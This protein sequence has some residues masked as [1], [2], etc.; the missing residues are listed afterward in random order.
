MSPRFVFV[1][2]GVLSS[3]GKGIASS[4]LGALL[5]ARGFRVRLRKLDP[6]LNV[7]S[8]TMS[9]LQHGEVFVTDDGTET[10]LDLGHYERF[11]G[12][13]ASRKDCLTTGRIYLEVFRKERNGD[14]LGQTIQVIPHIVDEIKNTLIQ[15]AEEN[16]FMIFEIGG[17]VGDIE[18]LPFLE[19]I[20]QL[21]NELGKERTL[22][23]HTAW[24][25][26]LKVAGEMKT[27][28]FQH[29]V[30]EL[31][32]AGIHP[33]ILLC[34]CE[35]E[36]PEETR[37]KIGAFCGNIPIENVISA[38]NVENIYETTIVYHESGLD[39]AVCR[40]FKETSRAPDLSPW[41]RVVRSIREAKSE[42]NIGII[43]KYTEIWDAYR[44][45]REALV[46][47]GIERCIRV[48]KEFVDSEAL[49]KQS[50]VSAVLRNFDGI[51][52]PGGFGSRGTEGKIRAIQYARTEGI[53]F[54]GICFGLQLAVIEAARN[55]AGMTGASSTEFGHAD[56]PVIA[57]LAEWMDRETLKKYQ[58]RMELGGT[59]RL[60]SYPC[61]LLEGS[62]LHSIYGSNVISERHRHRYEVN[63][64]YK[65][66]LEKNA[67]I[68]FS[69]TSLDGAL[70]EAIERKDHPWFVGVQF[71]PEFLSRPLMPHPLF[72]S[73]IRAAQIRQHE[74]NVVKADAKL[75]IG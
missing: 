55:I 71:H 65:E 49:E 67:G 38:R 18:G 17:T 8:G 43:G 19:A 7:D 16:D 60:G 11:T 15:D 5:R 61:R 41:Y 58:A 53:P 2:G 46:H 75:G 62:L 57:L 44:S 73:F 6:Y 66:R 37:R 36:V 63:S 48:N 39:E 56:D 21:R 22:L 68:T 32:H 23:I 47:G 24:V 3:L 13:H 34:R 45:V 74:R 70:V 72:S 26:D 69:G 12:T 20:R 10:D 31:Q 59:M 1:T 28:P 27:K 52:I 30:R 64:A 54:L 14:F 9:P 33:N 29:S 4:A 51:L 35:R 40:H 42:V 25:I 50:D